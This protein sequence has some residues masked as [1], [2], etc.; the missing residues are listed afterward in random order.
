MYPK[1]KLLTAKRKKELY[2]LAQLVLDDFP[3]AIPIFPEAIAKD[4][5]IKC[6]IN[7]YNGDFNGL[8][9]YLNGRFHIFLHT[10]NSETIQSPTIRYSLAH[11]LGHYFIGSHRTELMQ[12]GML[13]NDTTDP[14]LT[15][16][17][18]EKEAEYFAS[19]LLMPEHHY[20]KD[21][22]GKPFSL[23]LMMELRNKYRVSLTAAILRYATLGPQPLFVICSRPAG[24]KWKYPGRNF[25]FHKLR[26]SVYGS[27]AEGT[28]AGNFHYLATARLPEKSG[29]LF[30]NI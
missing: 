27:V 18:Q 20:L 16:S 25:P 30:F 22:E 29:S 8:I 28:Q 21:I 12:E 5:G 19:C 14:M 1:P 3:D 17:L 15:D 6:T 9:E 2:D 26:I 24:I 4:E 10:E 23:E 13:H 11:E 7:D